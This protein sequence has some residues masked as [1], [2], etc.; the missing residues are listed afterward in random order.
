MRSNPRAAIAYIAI[1]LNSPNSKKSIFDYSRSKHITF[2]GN[3]VPNKV[4]IYDHDRGCHIT[5]ERE[6]EQI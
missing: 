5:G 4:T 1:K 2:S 6:Q 3:I